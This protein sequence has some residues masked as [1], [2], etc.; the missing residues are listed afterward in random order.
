MTGAWAYVRMLERWPRAA[1]APRAILV[2][3]IA[4]PFYVLFAYL[5]GRAAYS[6][7]SAVSGGVWRGFR[8]GSRSGAPPPGL[9]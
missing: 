9:C 7:S 1:I 8:P 3:A 5:Y 2:A 6:T 4:L